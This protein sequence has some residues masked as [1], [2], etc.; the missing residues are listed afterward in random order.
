M[1]SWKATLEKCIFHNLGTQPSCES[2]RAEVYV[3]SFADSA[4]NQQVSIEL[5]VLT[6]LA[7]NR[8]GILRPASL[9]EVP[10]SSEEDLWCFDEGIAVPDLLD[11][12]QSCIR[13]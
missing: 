9:Y 4:A 5:D 13:Q 2:G 12:P 1:L 11:Q 7:G 10:H 8:D 3:R 6:W